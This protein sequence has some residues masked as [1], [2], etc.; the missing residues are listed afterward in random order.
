[1][2]DLID[3]I[4]RLVL[5]GLVSW[6]VLTWLRTEVAD[7]IDEKLELEVR[8]SRTTH[9]IRDELRRS[10]QRLVDVALNLPNRDSDVIDVD[11]SGQSRP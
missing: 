7:Q 4:L 5:I 11:G 9:E 2:S 6:L 3:F 8:R 10:S 1:M